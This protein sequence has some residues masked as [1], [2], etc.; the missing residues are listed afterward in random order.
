[1]DGGV[2]K[3]VTEPREFSVL[4]SRW[5]T[6]FFCDREAVDFVF[7]VVYARFRVFFRDFGPRWHTAA[8]ERGLFTIGGRGWFGR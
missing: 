6:S 4:E 8:N 2:G 1:M 5:Q 7:A 3:K